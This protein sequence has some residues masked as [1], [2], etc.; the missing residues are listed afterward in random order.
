MQT[1]RSC[2]RVAS[3]LSKG[4][5]TARP[6]WVRILSLGFGF[7]LQWIVQDRVAS[8]GPTGGM[9][10]PCGLP[11]LSVPRRC[12]PCLP[13]NLQL[14]RPLPCSDPSSAAGV[15]LAV[16]PLI[17][18]PQAREFRADNDL[19]ISSP[20]GRIL[21]KH[22]SIF[23]HVSPFTTGAGMAVLEML[24]EMVR[25]IELLGRITLSKFVSLL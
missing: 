24:S 11:P 7:V 23:Q 10:A 4:G 2:R 9:T 3:V 19:I 17:C 12:H 1:C 18:R 25:A 14:S 22:T 20:W 21:F 16:A 6:S 8:N 13:P 5:G 15:R